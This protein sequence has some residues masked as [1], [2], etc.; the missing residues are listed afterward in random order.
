MIAG[1]LSHDAPMSQLHNR[2]ARPIV[3]TKRF[4]FEAQ[5]VRGSSKKHLCAQW[6]RGS[7]GDSSPSAQ[8]RS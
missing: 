3:C 7:A 1:T 6:S 2:A 8:L 5:S 4:A